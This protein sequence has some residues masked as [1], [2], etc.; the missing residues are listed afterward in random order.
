MEF[1][2]I[3]YRNNSGKNPINEF[4]LELSKSNLKLVLKA[5]ESIEKLRNR[6]YHK[7]PF[8]KYLEPDLW[9]LR[10]KVGTDILRIIYTFNKGQIIVLLHAFIKKKQKTP[11]SELE[12]ARKRLIELK[13]KGVN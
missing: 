10:I 3:F 12:T 7:E 13:N 2:I 11:V 6:F 9:E 5:K 1:K 8:S 4:L